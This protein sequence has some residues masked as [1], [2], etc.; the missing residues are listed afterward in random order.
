[1]KTIKTTIALALLAILFTLPIRA[2]ETSTKSD[3]LKEFSLSKK[4]RTLYLTTTVRNSNEPWPKQKAVM[5]D[6]PKE[7]TLEDAVSL[8]NN[9]NISLSYV[10]REKADYSLSEMVDIFFNGKKEGIHKGKFSFSENSGSVKMVYDS[11]IGMTEE[12]FY[13]AQDAMQGKRNWSPKLQKIKAGLPAY[14]VWRFSLPLFP[15]ENPVA[16]LLSTLILLVGLMAFGYVIVRIR[17]FFEDKYDEEVA[18]W[19]IGA[20]LYGFVSLILYGIASTNLFLESN[21]GL[22]G[23]VILFTPFILLGGIVGF[24]VKQAEKKGLIVRNEVHV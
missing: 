11:V 18:S 19:E 1:M 3:T 17:R 21:P 14:L 24:I 7:M 15:P 8:Y 16:R 6:V 5:K 23:F 13:Y 22:V 4:D 2:A 12:G 9:G 10:V 20:M